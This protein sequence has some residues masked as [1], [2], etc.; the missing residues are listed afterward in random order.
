MWIELLVGVIESSGG[1]RCVRG[2]GGGCGCTRGSVDPGVLAK[3]GE[4]TEKLGLT[5]AV[6]V[7]SWVE[8]SRRA[9]GGVERILRSRQASARARS[10]TLISGDCGSNAVACDIIDGGAGVFI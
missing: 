10:M 3:G 9:S 4:I 5:A 7:R 1:R 2:G 8:Y 6:L